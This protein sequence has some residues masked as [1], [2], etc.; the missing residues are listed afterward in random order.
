M[1]KRSF[2]HALFILLALLFAFNTVSAQEA[3]PQITPEA[4][5]TTQPC[6]AGGSP[7]AAP[8]PSAKKVLTTFTIIADMARNVACGLVDVESITKPGAEIHHYEPTPSDIVRALNADLILDNGLGLETWADRF[9]ANV[10]NVPHI[11]LSTGVTPIIISGG[12]F[13]GKPNPHAWMSPTNALIYVENIR[14]ALSDLDPADA[15]AF[16]ENAQ[17][18]DAQIH[19]VDQYLKQALAVLPA[20]ERTLVSCEG[21]FSYLTRDTGMGELYLWA[22]NSD[23]EGTPQQIAHVIDQVNANHVPAVF[24]E[25]TVNDK[26]QLA[27]AAQTGA[28]FGGVLYVDSLTEANGPAPTYLKLLTVNA[29]TIVSGLLGTPAPTEEATTAQ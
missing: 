6:P 3:I 10:P 11:T 13:D 8:S 27:V 19:Q 26:A 23:Q 20:D 2:A 21:A 9:Y 4:A 28:R 5:Q 16:A 22:V 12:P 25:S 15:P 17:A 14:Q 24:C 7:D 29:Q 18:Y 1:F